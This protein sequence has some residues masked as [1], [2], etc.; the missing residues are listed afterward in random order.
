MKTGHLT[1]DIHWLGHSGFRWDGSRTVYFDPWKIGPS[2]KPADIVFVSHEHFDHCSKPDIKSIST[3][4][5]VVVTCAPAMRELRSAGLACKEIEVLAPGDTAEVYGVKIR[6]VASYNIG[7]PFHPK[8]DKKVG[9]IVTMDGISV[10][11][12]GDTDAI[13]EMK[14]L[15]CDVALLPV[16]G[17]YVMTPDE[18]ALVAADIKPKAAVPMH[19]AEIVGTAADAR[20]FRELLEGKV[21]VDILKKGE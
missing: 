21:E 18:A 11:H 15:R 20:R 5:T 14:G 16:S 17:T 12:A 1:K 4:E 7:K 8:A 6:A 13:P 19:Y 3:G 10:Y 2:A 9:F